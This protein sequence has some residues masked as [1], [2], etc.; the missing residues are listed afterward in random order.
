MVPAVSELLKH[1]SHTILTSPQL[2]D[3]PDPV[4]AV[5]SGLQPAFAFA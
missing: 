2:P 4:L 5:V 3:G 1:T